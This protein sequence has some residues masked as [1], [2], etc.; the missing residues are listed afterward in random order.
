MKESWSQRNGY[1]WVGNEENFN[2]LNSITTR[3]D[4]ILVLNRLKAYA[5]MPSCK[6][7]FLKEEIIFVRFYSLDFSM[8]DQ[9]ILI[10]FASFLQVALGDAWHIAD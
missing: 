10:F 4:N 3:T 2:L 9:A 8:M 1:L 7:H 6:K 5:K